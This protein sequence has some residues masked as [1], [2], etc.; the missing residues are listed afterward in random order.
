MNGLC[1]GCKKAIAGDQVLFSLDGEMLCPQCN[2]QDELLRMD[3]RAAG[4]IGKS[5]YSALALAALSYLVNPFFIV[6]MFAISSAV[7]T[8]SSFRSDNER[9]SKH[10]ANIRG[11]LLFCAYAAIA[12]TVLRFTGPVLVGVL[13]GQN[14]AL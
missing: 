9:F 10:V 13:S 14:R 8:I 7:Y 2:Q 12:L 5:A 4:N 1:S 6:T 3:I 11:R